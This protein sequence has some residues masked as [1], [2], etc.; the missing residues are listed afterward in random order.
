MKIGFLS[1]LHITHNTNFMEHAL[2]SV[3]EVISENQIDKLFLAGDTSNNYKT[4][5]KFID[6]LSKRGIDTYTILGNHEYWS[7]NYEQTKL[8]NN[9]RYLHG[10]TLDLANNVVIVGI[11]GFFDYS[12]VTQVENKYTNKVNKDI[13]R[14]KSI[15][16]RTFDLSRLKIKD[17]D[18]EKVFIDMEN[19]LIS[20]L[21]ANQGKQVI[22]FMHHVPHQDFII[23]ND[24]KTWTSNNSFMGS[25]RFHEIFKEYKVDKVIFGHTHT[26]FSDI[27]DDIEYSCNPV[28]YRDYEFEE[29]FQE[30]IK[31]M[32][33]VIEV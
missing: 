22:A 33:K 15:G 17:K 29:T 13:N 24:D 10:K 25:K 12:F 7:I 32:F 27:I 1:D 30:R 5:F 31:K 6:E 18:Y 2:N 26:Q 3:C 14:L 11:D 21:K 19:L 16:K 20:Q 28:G 23:Y 9:D 8:L 4:T